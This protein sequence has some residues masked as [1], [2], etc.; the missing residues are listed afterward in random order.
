MLIFTREFKVQ[1]SVMFKFLIIT[2]TYLST[3]IFIRAT[4]ESI[5]NYVF[6]CINGSKTKIMK[7]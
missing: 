2:K 4:L 1:L 6:T 5:E 7:I 3:K